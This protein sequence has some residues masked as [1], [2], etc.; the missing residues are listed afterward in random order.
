MVQVTRDVCCGRPLE[1]RWRDGAW[2]VSGAW[3]V[4]A[5][6]RMQ[7]RTSDTL[8]V[9]IEFDASPLAPVEL[10]HTLRLPEGTHGVELVLL[11]GTGPPVVVASAH[12]S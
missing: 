11:R 9:L 7:L 2:H 4:F 10:D 3:G 6:A 5:A 1:L 12:V 8:E